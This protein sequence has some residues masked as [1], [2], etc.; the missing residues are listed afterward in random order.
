MFY[1]L[2]PNTLIC[3]MSYKISTVPVT[4]SFSM[5]LR[6]LKPIINY[7][8]RKKFPLS[9][10]WVSIA[11]KMDVIHLFNLL[12]DFK[13]IGTYDIRYLSFTF[14]FPL[15]QIWW[16]IS[17]PQRTHYYWLCSLWLIY[18]RTRHYEKIL[19]SR[20]SHSSKTWRSNIEGMQTQKLQN[21]NYCIF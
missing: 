5:K 17:T 20:R 8:T 19:Q 14:F 2:A 4:V 12:F 3:I 18:D 16:K 11:I 15:D 21:E 1:F 10:H 6:F 7:F 9:K 13:K